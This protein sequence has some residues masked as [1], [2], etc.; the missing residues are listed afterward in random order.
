MCQNIDD[1]N[2]GCVLIMARLY[3]SFPRP[4]VLEV[5]GIDGGE[6]LFTDE[7]PARLAER[8]GVYVATVRFLADEGYLIT[9]QHDGCSAFA[10]ARLTSKGLAALNR[11][12]EALKPPAKT[13]G[14]RMLGITTD[15]AGA[16]G[17][18]AV[19]AAVQALLT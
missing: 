17:K 11:V 15:L 16:A 1:F 12:P 9:R 13:L 5:D 8:V 18:E 7:R 6:D 14:D 2:R 4:V 19:K 10:G 3:Q